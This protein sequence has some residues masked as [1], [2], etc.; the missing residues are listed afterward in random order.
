[1]PRLRSSAA[2]AALTLAVSAALGLAAA[3]AGRAEAGACDDAPPEW[4]VCED[5]EAGGLGWERWFAQSPWVECIS[6]PNG[7]NDPARI[8]LVDDPAQAH[9][10][11]WSLHMPAEAGGGYQGGALTWRSCD[12]PKRQGCRLTGRD[13]LYM[14]A[15]VR[16]ADDHQK[17]HHFLSID[18]TRPG[19]YWESDGNAGCR[20]NG[21]SW[22]GTTLDFNERR[23]LFFY[24]YF[25]GM[26][27]D[28]GGY[29]SGD[30]VR[31]ICDLCAT[32][33]MPCD[34]GPE[35]CWGNL[36]QSAAPVILPRGRWACLEIQMRL[37][38]PGQADGT[39]AYW[40]DGQLGHA[41][42]GMRWRETDALQLNKV[43][44]QHYLAAGDADRPNRVWFD[45]VVV[46]TA[47]IGCGF[48]PPASATAVTSPAA[49]TAVA[50]PSPSD[51]ATAAATSTGEPSPSP[52]P[53]P[54]LG[55][56]GSATPAR[57]RIALPWLDGGA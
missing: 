51:T 19:G 39:M 49:P 28:R 40:L 20:P 43:W 18:G 33:G 36:F 57:D 45:D 29:C 4:L 52:T 25:P 7:V 21:L 35:C 30:R 32:K 5:F 31:Q 55:P 24:T 6:C 27:C 42:A 3:V 10:G 47:P 16:L 54:T 9:G 50:S 41:Q 1:M 48:A 22:A 12:G 13:E 11:R 53:R 2:A 26:R 23:E 8:R 38:T 44:L 34:G 15:W 37:N 17:V 14:R 56:S 46:S